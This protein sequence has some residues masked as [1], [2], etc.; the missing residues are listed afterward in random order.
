MPKIRWTDIMPGQEN[1]LNYN[2]LSVS[3]QNS[4][5]VKSNAFMK[6]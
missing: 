1:N 4:V 2:N 5:V 3:K 6:L